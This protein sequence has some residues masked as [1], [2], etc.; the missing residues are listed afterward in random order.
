MD[1]TWVAAT[2]YDGSLRVFALV[3]PAGGG[4]GSGGASAARL[5]V[6]AV[7]A[8]DGAP[9]HVS[10]RSSRTHP[11]Q[12][13][14]LRVAAEVGDPDGGGRGGRA[15]LSAAYEAPEVPTP[16]ANTLRRRCVLTADVFELV[17]KAPA[18]SAPGG[19]ED[20][21]DAAPRGGG[22]VADPDGRDD[23]SGYRPDAHGVRY[24]L[25][26]VVVH[27][28]TVAPEASLFPAG[29]AGATPAPAAGARA[30]GPRPRSAGWPTPTPAAAPA[31]AAAFVRGW[32][33]VIAA[34]EAYN[35]R[36]RAAVAAAEAEAAGHGGKRGLDAAD[37][38]PAAHMPP[39]PGVL[40]RR[41]LV[42]DADLGELLV[43]APRVTPPRDTSLL[44]DPH[45]LA[46]R[47]PLA[48][49][50][51]HADGALW[52]PT[53]IAAAAALEAPAAG[54][55]GGGAA[56]AAGPGGRP[57]S[58][59]T[60]RACGGG[61]GGASGGSSDALL[62]L[63]AASEFRFEV[64]FY[65]GG[66]DAGGGGGGGGGSAAFGG[67]LGMSVATHAE[68]EMWLPALARACRRARRAARD[69]RVTGATAAPPP[70]RDPR[71]ALAALS[72]VVV[73]AVGWSPLED[74]AI[75]ALHGGALAMYDGRRGAWR[76][77]PPRPSPGDG[78]RAAASLVAFHALGA[79]A[80]IAYADGRVRA[81][82]KALNDLPFVATHGAVG[83]GAASR[84]AAAGGPGALLDMGA[85]TS[86]GPVSFMSSPRAAAAAAARA[87]AA[88]SAS[89]PFVP[90]S[91]LPPRRPP[92]SAA[93]GASG[94]H[95]VLS[96]L[97]GAKSGASAAPRVVGS[98]HRRTAGAGPDGLLDL[99]GRL[100]VRCAF[101]RSGAVR[102]THIRAQFAAAPVL[103]EWAPPVTVSVSAA[104]A[105]A[106][107][108]GG[109]TITPGAVT[110]ADSPRGALAAADAPLVAPAAAGPEGASAVAARGTLVERLVVVF[111]RGPAVVVA[112]DVGGSAG[113][114]G[115]GFPQLIAAH[116]GVERLAA[117][118]EVRARARADAGGA[119]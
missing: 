47:L 31:A 41:L 109:T 73:T 17:G 77:A 48:G 74:A 14:R 102:L 39:P 52:T 26:H 51:V 83:G 45:A 8:M 30:E 107:R 117:A 110:M 22:G 57:G 44:H 86:P 99:A 15:G 81:V 87:A 64:Q 105:G 27:A 55:G 106:G 111:D 78:G 43:Y 16:V 70:Q 36:A 19:A 10:F 28:E 34:P 114:G 94:G 11:R 80:V 38:D 101:P 5:G 6:R 13:V 97:S 49:A 113:G 116:L 40:G 60:G 71:P 42:I 1:G 98:A 104:A 35:A 89:S 32:V 108:S 54:G 75:L 68:R 66:A 2:L 119:V 29:R 76:R 61:G 79:L 18:P 20:P 56:A 103:A 91:R 69:G 46:A 90:P 21:F 72:D 85:L 12:L 4:A 33:S 63:A 7:A 112:I 93:D 50:R 23:V 25:V 82:D 24:G 9:G 88:A 59:A 3:W 37:F 84:D 92:P 118:V 100:Q 115:L 96:P 67:A 95:G 65:G 53:R 62:S 58:G